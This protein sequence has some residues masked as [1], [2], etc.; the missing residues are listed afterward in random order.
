MLFNKCRAERNIIPVWL[1]LEFVCGTAQ[2]QT[3]ISLELVK[4]SPTGHAASENHSLNSLTSK[5]MSKGA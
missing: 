3:A 5:R 2:S 4:I 1:N